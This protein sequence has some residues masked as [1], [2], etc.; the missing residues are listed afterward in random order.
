MRITF[1]PV[2]VA[3]ALV[4]PLHAAWTLGQTPP[5]NPEATRAGK[6]FRLPRSIRREQDAAVRNSSRDSGQQTGDGMD[7]VGSTNVGLMSN[8]IGPLRATLSTTATASSASLS[9]PGTFLQPAARALEGARA[10]REVGGQVVQR[11]LPEPS[12]PCFAPDRRW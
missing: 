7:Q 1:H 10:I 2:V 4:A 12:S 3:I 9:P 5:P 8:D 11:T 6:N